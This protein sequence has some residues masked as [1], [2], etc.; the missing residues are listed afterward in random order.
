M[1]NINYN[2]IRCYLCRKKI[3]EKQNILVDKTL[4]P[5]SKK[6][7]RD[8]FNYLA[9]CINA[10]IF[11]SHGESLCST[12][13]NQIVGYD[14]TVV[15]VIQQQKCLAKLVEKAATNIDSDYEEQ[16]F[17]DANSFTEEY[18]FS[19]IEISDNEIDE[20]MKEAMST[21]HNTKPAKASKNTRET[22]VVQEVMQCNFCPIGF[23]SKVRLQ[24]HMSQAHKKYRC[25]LCSYTHRNEDYVMLHMNTHEGRNENQCRFCFKEFTTKISAIR[26]MEVHLNSKKYQC[27]KCGLCFSQTTVLYN[28]KLQHEAEEQPLRCEKCNQIFK[29]K[30]TYTHHMI[31]HRADRPRYSCDICSKTFTEKYTLKVHKRSHHSQNIEQ[32]NA[33]AS[34]TEPESKFRCV[35]CDQAF[36]NKDGLNKHMEKEHDVIVKSLTLSNFTQYEICSNEP[37]KHC[38]ICG[39]IFSTQLNLDHHLKNV[40]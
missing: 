13:Y 25:T 23:K 20:I 36:I 24:K 1:D 22:K 27:D 21:P 17:E 39:H 26:H 34:H 3:N 18:F 32:L 15:K 19:N 35:I 9:R 11:I 12:C 37:K 7:I 31:T 33:E 14:R 29:T 40:H 6:S 10:E 16:F 5:S 30:R 4:C 28:H 8:V 38:Q 2:I